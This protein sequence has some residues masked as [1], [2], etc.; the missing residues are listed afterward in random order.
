M[1]IKYKD[2]TYDFIVDLGTLSKVCQRANIK[3]SEINK[4]FFDHPKNLE[5]IFQEGLKRG[6]RKNGE[7][8]ELS[9]VD[10]ENIMVD[11]IQTMFGEINRSMKT[12]SSGDADDSKKNS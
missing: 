1:E 4:D 8:L 11:N 3:L 2:K 10:Y 9:E 12:D 5:I 6:A 7:K